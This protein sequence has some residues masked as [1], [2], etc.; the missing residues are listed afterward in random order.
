ME[1]NSLL[2]GVTGTS[3]LADV[4]GSVHEVVLHNGKLEMAVGQHVNEGKPTSM[5]T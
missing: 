4:H 1:G 5:P 2:G 3:G